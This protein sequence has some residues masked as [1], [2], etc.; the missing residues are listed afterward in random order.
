MKPDKLDDL[1][2]CLNNLT[3]AISSNKESV[4][5]L[6][7][8]VSLSGPKFIDELKESLNF[9]EEE[10]YLVSKKSFES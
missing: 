10:I 4:S 5:K 8:D 7:R 6:E 1:E 9:C 2:V 3:T